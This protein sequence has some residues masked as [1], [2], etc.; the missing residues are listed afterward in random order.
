MVIN[1]MPDKEI[2]LALHKAA[3]L[4]ENKLAELSECADADLS[5]IYDAMRYSLLSGGKRLR[6]FLTLEFARISAL[7][8][9]KDP[10]SAR[11]A[12][13]VF[14]A[15]VEM[16]H[17]YS[18][19]HDDLPCM[20]DDALRRGKPTCHIKFGEANALLAGDA[21]L[22]RAFG[23]AAGNR[24]VSPETV[25]RAVSLMSECAGADGMVGGQVIDLASEGKNVGIATLEKLQT[26]KT[27][28]LIR[29][30]SLLGCIAG[31]ASEGLTRV[32]E[33]YS[34]GIGRAFQVI[35]D[36]LD[37]VGDEKLLAKPIGSDAASGK[38]TFATVMTVDEARGY[39]ERVTAMATDAV[40]RFAGSEAL[41]SLAEYLLTRKS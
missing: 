10:E 25:V 18:L 28:E 36:I 2:S 27:G 16:I 35:D 38:S 37:V 11:D 23:V 17:T 5:V 40:K 29:C 1:I 32:A 14:G 13:L 20:D 41:I 26:K 22:T 33:S 7:E 9:G 21:L 24:S 3:L 30:A 39:A 6:P 31:G 34:M 12:A 4:V 19:I 15:A 8:S